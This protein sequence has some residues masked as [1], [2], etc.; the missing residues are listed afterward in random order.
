M[1]SKIS[2]VLLIKGRRIRPLMEPRSRPH[3]AMGAGSEEI[4][5]MSGNGLKVFLLQHLLTLK[6]NPNRNPALPPFKDCAQGF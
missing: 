4:L 1:P 6:P 3:S 5:R 2:H